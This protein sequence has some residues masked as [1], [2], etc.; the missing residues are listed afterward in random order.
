MTPA[1][2]TVIR[3]KAARY[4]AWA[5]AE[6][7]RTSPMIEF[8]EK[9]DHSV[10]HDEWR[11]EMDAHFE[12]RR[13]WDDRPEIKEIHQYRSQLYDL[14]SFCRF[15]RKHPI[16]RL[17]SKTHHIGPRYYPKYSE[18]EMLEKFGKKYEDSPLTL[19][20]E[21]EPSYAFRWWWTDDSDA[22]LKRRNHAPAWSWGD[23]FVL[24]LPD[25]HHAGRAFF[26]ANHD[27]LSGEFGWSLGPKT[28]FAKT[29]GFG[30]SID[31]DDRDI[32]LNVK[33]PLLGYLYLTLNH[34]A[35][36]WLTF[37]KERRYTT[38]E[39]YVFAS[40][41]EAKNTER[42]PV[43]HRFM[44]GQDVAVIEFDLSSDH[45]R[46]ALWSIGEHMQ[47]EGKRRFYS[48][49]PD[50]FFGRAAYTNEKIGPP[51]QAVACF[52]EGQYTLTLQR[53][54]ATWKRPHWPWAYWRKSVDITLERPPEFQGKGENSWDCGPDAIYGMSSEGYSYEDAVATY[55]K[56]VLRERAK[57]GHLEPQHRTVLTEATA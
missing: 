36:V 17:I 32:S 51:V 47:S 40:E 19:P 23:M 57:R 29:L 1:R 2:D 25:L 54:V 48:F 41:E 13:A 28:Y 16:S 37:P 5:E 55:V 52:P 45:V 6:L 21:R 31:G 9:L 22:D 11:A 26:Y 49:W 10:H 39:P 14:I 20:C 33:I 42:K 34:M 8:P 7:E 38:Y 15:R 46:G 12:R 4:M 50:R 43:E 24:G 27:R 44:Q 30:L 53:E 56:A 3:G 35:P 18:A